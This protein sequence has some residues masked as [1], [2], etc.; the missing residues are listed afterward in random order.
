MHIIKL[1]LCPR[2]TEDRPRKAYRS[3]LY[4]KYLVRTD[5]GLPWTIV[6]YKKARILLPKGKSSEVRMRANIAAGAK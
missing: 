2:F 5:I 1:Y 6:E 3:A 4:P